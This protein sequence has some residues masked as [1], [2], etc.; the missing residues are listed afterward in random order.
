MIRLVALILAFAAAGVASATYS[1]VARDGETGQLGV[2]VQSHWF[3]VGSVV[4]WAEAG[5]G[6]V[7]TQSLAEIS[8]GPMG[9]DLMRSGKSAGDAFE[10]LRSVDPAPEVRQVAMIDADGRV[11]SFTGDS[12]I[13]VVGSVSHVNKNGDSWACQAN[14]MHLEGVAEAMSDAFEE[15][16]GEPLSERMMRAMEAAQKAG[17]DVRG[18]Q[19]A[20]ILVVSGER[21]AGWRGREMD[22]RVADHTEPLKELRRLLDLHRAY[23]EMNAGDRA[24]EEDDLGAALEHYHAAQELNPTNVEMSFWTG[25]TLAGNGR[26][27]EAIPFFRTA[28]NDPNGT[29]SGAEGG[30]DWPGLLRRLPQSGLFPD[31]DELIER[32]LT[33]A[34]H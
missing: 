22:L 5:V 23:D 1:I 34:G 33:E 2:A 16:A 14:M 17:G 12:C 3:D 27:E 26:V 30:S 32:I 28:F 15:S 4:P 24:L 21:G 13:P 9:L 29:K 18:K 20:S 31:D 11:L 7:A 19:S 10:A 25:V 8:Y 6:A